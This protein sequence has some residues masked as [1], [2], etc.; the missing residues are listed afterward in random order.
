MKTILSLIV[1]LLPVFLLSPLMAEQINFFDNFQ[2]E[3]TGL[4]YTNFANWNV[5]KGSVDSYYGLG[6]DRSNIFV[7]MGGT[8]GEFG[9]LTSKQTFSFSSGYIYEVSFDLAGSQR[10]T[11]EEVPS[12]VTM[13]LGNIYQNQSF[14][15]LAYDP[16]QTFTFV[17]TVNSPISAN[18]VFEGSGINPNVG[19]LLDNVR[20]TSTPVPEPSIMVLL[21]IS[22]A[23]VVSLMR[24]W[25]E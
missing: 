13:S 21:G 23:S 11:W 3:I 6:F 9:I 12:T 22:I 20:I 15:L 14:Y 8:T 17:F 19:L 25:K 1:M 2:E 24:R 7:D 4:N 10:F 5:T 16:W 18:L